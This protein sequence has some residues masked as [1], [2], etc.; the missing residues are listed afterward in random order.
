WI[1][2]EDSM[3]VKQDSIPFTMFDLKT[4]LRGALVLQSK[5]LR[6]S[7]FVDWADAQL[8]SSDIGFGKNKL[9]ADS[10]D[11]LIKSLDPKKFALQT[12]DVNAS[13]DFDKRVGDFKSNT[14]DAT[15]TFP[16]NQYI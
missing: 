14:D 10:A 9:K 15:T 5:G 12:R 11:F 6:G 8:S 16:Y 2:Y 3:I 1:P 7:G 4:T 13:I